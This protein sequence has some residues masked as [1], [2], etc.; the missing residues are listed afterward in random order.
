MPVTT[1]TSQDV[2]LILRLLAA[3]EIP[4]GLASMTSTC[5]GADGSRARPHFP[6]P[7]ASHSGRSHSCGLKILRYSLA[8]S[9]GFLSSGVL[10]SMQLK[11]S[12]HAGHCSFCTGNEL[13]LE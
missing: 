4:V 10:P 5:R 8:S 13:T 2:S 6:K 3:L 11:S 12:P 1:S 7:A 9:F